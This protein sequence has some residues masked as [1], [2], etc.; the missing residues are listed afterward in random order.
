MENLNSVKQL[1]QLESLLDEQSLCHKGKGKHI[2]RIES[3][4]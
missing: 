4:I 1:Q 3:T 2:R